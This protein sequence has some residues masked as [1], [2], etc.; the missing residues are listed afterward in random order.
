MTGENKRRK[1]GNRKESRGAYFLLTI[2]TFSSQSFLSFFSFSIVQSFT[3]GAT[4]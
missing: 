2:K 1:E 3:R 4:N